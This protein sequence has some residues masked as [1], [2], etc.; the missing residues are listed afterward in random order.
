MFH[1]VWLRDGGIISHYYTHLLVSSA[2]TSA[3]SLSD[4]DR[5]VGVTHCS[6]ILPPDFSQVLQQPTGIGVVSF[7][8]T[9]IIYR[10]IIWGYTCAVNCKVLV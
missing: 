8:D 2:V 5:T 3:P 7:N 1:G 9:A 6:R 10:E 4:F